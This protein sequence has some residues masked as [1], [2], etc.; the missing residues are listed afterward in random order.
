M[1]PKVDVRIIDF[2]HT[3]KARS[4]N[5]KGPDWGFIWG[6]IELQETLAR[7]LHAKEELSQML[8]SQNEASAE[9][10]ELAENVC[11]YEAS[12]SEEDDDNSLRCDSISSE[13]GATEE[14]GSSGEDEDDHHDD[15]ASGATTTITVAPCITSQE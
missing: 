2:A 3:C 8:C 1:P 10:H 11:F 14:S 6:L 9:G 12:S 5:C 13:N 15:N 7:I 4:H